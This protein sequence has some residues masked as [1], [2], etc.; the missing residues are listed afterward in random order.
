MKNNVH[1]F[2]VP[3]IIN[4]FVGG[5]LVTSLGA[6]LLE[7]YKAKIKPTKKDG[8]PPLSRKCSLADLTVMKHHRKEMIRRDSL[9]NVPEERYKAVGRDVCK[10]NLRFD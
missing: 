2:V 9:M 6:A 4:Y 3:A 8:K 1:I 7:Y 5:L 10:S